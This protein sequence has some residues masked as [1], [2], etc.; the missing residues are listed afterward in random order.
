M[1]YNWRKSRG[2]DG[3]NSPRWRPA[4]PLMWGLCPHL[5]PC[6]AATLPFPAR[7]LTPRLFTGPWPL[8]ADVPW[9]LLVLK[10]PCSWGSLSRDLLPNLAAPQ[11]HPALHLASTGPLPACMHVHRAGR[12]VGSEPPVWVL[13]SLTRTLKILDFIW[14]SPRQQ[15]F[16]IPATFVPTKTSAQ[17]QLSPSGS[18]FKPELKLSDV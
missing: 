2:C 9:G 13:G 12:P 15:A 11:P 7:L 16:L 10:P 17:M 3:N 5:A 14:N 18:D 1:I 8:E 4:P 6:P